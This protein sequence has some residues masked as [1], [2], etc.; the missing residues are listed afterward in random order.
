MFKCDALVNAMIEACVKKDKFGKVLWQITPYAFFG[1]FNK[2]DGINTYFIRELRMAPKSDEYDVCRMIPDERKTHKTQKSSA[3]K[4]ELSGLLHI[5]TPVAFLVCYGYYS[6]V[7]DILSRCGWFT[8]ATDYLGNNV[9][10]VLVRSIMLNDEEVAQK[11]IKDAV[12]ALQ[13]IRANPPTPNPYD[14]VKDVASLMEMK[15]KEDET[16]SDWIRA[17]RETNELFTLLLNWK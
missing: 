5:S 9:M 11:M 6:Q 4:D 16:P 1:K 12:D 17:S 3:S 13:N 2:E 7:F 8:T 14:I 15:N 10:H